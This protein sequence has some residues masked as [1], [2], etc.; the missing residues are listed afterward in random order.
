MTNTHPRRQVAMAIASLL[1]AVAA[2]A[3]HAAVSISGGYHFD[4]GDAL[5]VG[6]GNLFEPTRTLWVSNGS[7]SVLGGALLST[8]VDEAACGGGVWCATQISPSPSRAARA[9]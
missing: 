8:R 3:V 5:P 1:L 9:V 2:P 7:V 6:P 4:P